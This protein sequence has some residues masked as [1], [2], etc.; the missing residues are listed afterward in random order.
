MAE[1]ETLLTAAGLQ[2]L[3]EELDYLKHAKRKEV[4][5]RIKTA[6]GFG[7]LSENSEYDDAKKEQAIVESRISS[8]EKTLR[9]V[10]IIDQT[11]VDLDRVN[12]G[13]VVRLKD[14]DSGD[15]LEYA[16]VGSMEANPINGRI[17]NES[18]LGQAL[19]GRQVGDVIEVQ[20]P[21]GSFKYEVVEIKL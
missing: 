14:L 11:T 7:D 5:E 15:E 2:K 3:E 18:P 1:K 17:S 13:A 20:A 9:N 16:V 6:I 19:M 8:L 4:A 21:A 12:V 10:R